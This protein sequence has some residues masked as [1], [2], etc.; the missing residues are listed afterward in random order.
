MLVPW[1]SPEGKLWR[2][3]AQFI[4]ATPDQALDCDEQRIDA[5]YDGFLC[6]VCGGAIT[7]SGDRTGWLLGRSVIG[8]A[9][10]TR[11]AWLSLLSCPRLK[12]DGR[13]IPVWRCESKDGYRWDDPDRSKSVGHVVATEQAAVSSYAELEQA[14]R[15]LKRNAAPP[16]CPR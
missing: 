11:S 2:M 4:A 13:D 1:Y 7:T 12:E 10:C 14:F 15:Q 8:G 9:C 3:P 16:L 5:C 6:T